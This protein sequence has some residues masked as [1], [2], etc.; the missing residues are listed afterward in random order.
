MFSTTTMASSTTKPTAM[1]SAISDRLS[2]LKLS[3]Y[4]AAARAQ[5]RQRHGDARNERRPEIAQE[6]QNHH[7]HQR[8][9][10]PERELDV[11]DR[12]A[13]RRGAIEDGLD[14]D[15]RRNAGGE[16]RQLR[17]DLIDRVDDV[18]AGLLEHRQ[19][20]AVL[21]V[22]IGGDG[23]VDRVGNRLADVAHADRRAVA[24][25]QD[26]VVERL[27]VDVIWSLV[28]IVKL[29]LSVLI[30]PLATLV[31]EL[32]SALRISSS[33]MPLEASLAGSTWMR[34]DGVRSPKIETCATPGTCEICWARNRS[35]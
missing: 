2:R 27:G 7:H 15:R 24:V 11:G 23:A 29:V 8:D 26:D 32:T 35:A 33:V 5:Q 4:I 6:Q 12:G 14:L 1:V 3:R 16:L 10:Q 25:G 28:A 17:L 13:N 9:G 21:V 19:D 20:D 31:V 30:V 22:L 18:G 34:I